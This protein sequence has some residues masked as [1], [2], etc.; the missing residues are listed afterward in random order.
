MGDL[1]VNGEEGSD[2]NFKVAF[3]FPAYNAVKTLEN[4]LSEIPNGCAD[5]M[6]LVDDASSDLT[7]KLAQELGLTVV[8]HETN[9]GYGANQKTC[10]FMA[11]ETDADCVVMLHPDNQYDARVSLAMIDL[12]R[13]GICDVI[14][15]NRI[16]T[17]AEAL[18]GGMP[19]WKYFLNRTSTFLENLL[20]GQSIGDFHSGFRAYSR[21]ALEVIPFNANSDDF[22]FDQ[23]FLMQAIYFDFKI[24]DVPVP[25]RYMKEASSISFRRSLQYGVGAIKAFWAMKLSQWNLRSDRRFQNK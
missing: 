25:V 20:L 14:L 1:F 22:A 9:L 7:V 15:G 18:N 2:L 6:I 10:Y 19:R 21:R 3:V 4:T 17:R 23:E 8:R 13:L 11:L 5:Y 24:G 16:R 12:I